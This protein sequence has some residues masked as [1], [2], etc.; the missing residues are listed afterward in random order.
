[1]KSRFLIISSIGLVMLLF[2]SVVFAAGVLTDDAYVR[3]TSP[4]TNYGQDIYLS[5]Y[6][7]TAAC[8]LTDWS[9]IKFDLN[10][11]TG[12]IGRATVT[13]TVAANPSSIQPGT[14][15][16][17]YQVSDGWDEGSI[18]AGTAPALG[19]V[20]QTLPAP[21]GNGQ[22][23]TFG[24]AVGSSALSDYLATQ[25]GGDKVASM[26]LALT[27]TCGAQSSAVRFASSENTTVAVPTLNLYTPNSVT[28]TGSS[29]QQTNSLPLY[30]GL[31]ALA[32]VAAIGVGLS[33]RRTAA[34]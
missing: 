2:A 12:E 31:G 6:G 19:T 22:M 32:L 26:A 34:R 1:M 18:T 8:N 13:L 28:L 30:A 14:T 27:G 17:L 16:T 24:D 25:A 3:G 33:R 29:A 23:L 4:G 9:F 21:T 20:I 15:V 10:G 11:V 5:L 7:S